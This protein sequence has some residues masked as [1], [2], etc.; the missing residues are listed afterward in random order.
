MIMRRRAIGTCALFMMLAGCGA[1][2]DSLSGTVAQLA[3]SR[4]DGEQRTFVLTSASGEETELLFAAPPA[5]ATGDQVRVTGRR[6]QAG[7]ARGPLGLASRFQ[8]EDLERTLAIAQPLSLDAGAMVPARNILIVLFNFK[9]DDRQYYTTEEIQKRVLTDPDSVRAFYEEQ[10]FGL[11]RLTGKQNPSGDV[12]GWHTLDAYN[13]PCETTKWSNMALDAAR[14]SGLDTTVYQHFIFY[15]PSTPACDFGGLATVGGRFTWINGASI[16][17]MAHEFGHSFGLLHSNSYECRDKGLSRVTMS[18]DCAN[19]EYGNPFDVMG[20]GGLR[21]TNAYNKAVARWLGPSNI[22]DVQ[23]P[24]GLYKIVPQERP[25]NEPQL[26]AVP[27]DARRSYFLEYRQPFGFDNFAPGATAVTTAMLMVGYPLRGRDMPQSWLLDTTSNTTTLNDAPLAVGKTFQDQAAG[28]SITLVAVGPAGADI[29]VELTDPSP[30]QTVPADAGA[31]A[32]PAARPDAGRPPTAPD[33]EEPEGEAP[34]PKPAPRKGCS[35]ALGARAPG[36]AGVLLIMAPLVLRRRR[37]RALVLALVL[38]GCGS[39]GLPVKTAPDADEPEPVEPD[40]ARPVGPD[41][42]IDSASAAADAAPRLD[43][44]TRLVYTVAG[45][46]ADVADLC[47]R[48]A[49]THCSQLERCAPATFKTSYNDPS[50][51]RA[52]VQNT[53]RLNVQDPSRRVTVAAYT[54]CVDDLA[55]RTCLDVYWGRRPASC[56]PPMG[57]TAENGACSATRDCQQGLT[58]RFEPNAR[59]GKCV[60]GLMAGDRCSLAPGECVLGTSCVRDECTAALPLGAPCKRTIAGCATGLICTDAGCAERTGDKGT[61]CGRA[62][63]CDPTKNLYCNLATALCDDLPP[64]GGKLGDNCD[65][66]NEMGYAVSC[67]P[68]LYCEANAGT[69]GGRCRKYAAAGEG[70]DSLR[71]PLCLPPAVCSRGECRVAEIVFG[72]ALPQFPA[73]CQ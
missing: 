42:G 7:E 8:V 12:T 38:G 70:C 39:H 58:C 13:I 53:C 66:Y 61:A 34:G 23:K 24:G 1:P 11:I 17:T 25:S 18:D 63:V 35:C 68:G 10:S 30:V 20:R 45:A 27:R 41:A 50:V 46:P 52:R 55:K 54:T 5:L 9:N 37:L 44:P 15:F 73:V 51:C 47:M 65:T 26:L 48:E 67:M 56:T 4:P 72:T 29:R 2:D 59:C 3:I 19:V 28:V 69:T 57:N 14:R 21:H 32:A 49:E 31:D 64:P 62:D 60:P 16:S 6:L 22:I 33:A 36:G 43:A 40:A 71:G